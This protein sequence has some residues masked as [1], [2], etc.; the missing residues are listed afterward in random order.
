MYSLNGGCGRSKGHVCVLPVLFLSSW[1]VWVENKHWERASMNGD[2]LFLKWLYALVC[3]C[4]VAAFFIMTPGRTQKSKS[5]FAYHLWFA[6]EQRCNYSS[7][8][9]CIPHERSSACARLN[10]P[11]SCLH[12]FRQR[13]RNPTSRHRQNPIQKMTSAATAAGCGTGRRGGRERV[14][15]GEQLTRS[16]TGKRGDLIAQLAKS[17]GRK[18]QERLVPSV[19]PGSL[20][21]LV[22]PS[23]AFLS[24]LS[25]SLP[26]LLL[27]LPSSFPHCCLSRLTT[28][29]QNDQLSP[30]HEHGSSW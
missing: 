4:V 24:S 14:E 9:P 17:T 2:L 6:W 25:P 18:Q 29:E 7:S 10:E 28:S 20:L 30:P 27:L 16:D 12:L 13:S 21:L 1:Q 19:W 15:G 23:V 5:E 22:G 11:S 3:S 26:L 8:P